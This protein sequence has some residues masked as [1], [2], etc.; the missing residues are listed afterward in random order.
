[1]AGAEIR[2]LSLKIIDNVA[3]KPRGYMTA[4]RLMK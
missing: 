4:R 2:R 3:D 1:M